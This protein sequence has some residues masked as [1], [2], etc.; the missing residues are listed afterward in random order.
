MKK[1]VNPNGRY[2]EVNGAPVGAGLMARTFNRWS[3]PMLIVSA[4]AFYAAASEPHKAELRK[5]MP[6]KVL[7]AAGLAVLQRFY[8][9]YLTKAYFKT[10]HVIDTQPGQFNTMMRLNQQRSLDYKD[11][12]MP[13]SKS[14]L[15]VTAFSIPHT[16]AL[17]PVCAEYVQTRKMVKNL[18]SGKWALIDR[19]DMQPTQTPRTPASP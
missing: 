2:L 11:R 4:S 8:A 16:F 3:A 7:F 10:N 9:S 1:Q 18:A 6:E 17:L 15:I 13:S 14:H 12:G 19:E 5:E